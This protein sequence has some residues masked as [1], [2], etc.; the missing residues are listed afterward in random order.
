MICVLNEKQEKCR[1]IYLWHIN[2]KESIS[3]SKSHKHSNIKELHGKLSEKCDMAKQLYYYTDLETLLKMRHPFIAFKLALIALLREA[4]SVFF[5]ADSL[6]WIISGD[7]S[8]K[9]PKSTLRGL[10][11][12]LRKQELSSPRCRRPF[13]WENGLNH[14]RLRDNG[15]KHHARSTS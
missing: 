9:N 12:G 4:T 7:T 13:N 6:R 2:T 1:E 5:W 8:F 10:W 11:S 14:R 3:L 15:L